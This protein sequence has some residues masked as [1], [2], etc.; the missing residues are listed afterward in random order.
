MQYDRIEVYSSK[1]RR[2]GYFS[3]FSE[4]YRYTQACVGP[5]ENAYKFAVIEYAGRDEIRLDVDVD[6]SPRSLTWMSGAPIDG[7]DITPCFGLGANW[8]YVTWPNVVGEPDWDH[9]ISFDHGG[10]T[11]YL[12]RWV[13][14]AG[15]NF[16]PGL[17]WAPEEA[18]RDVDLAFSPAFEKLMFVVEGTR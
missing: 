15:V 3:L 17:F 2:L 5:L 12:A 13:W 14:N 6:P 18:I 16:H 1:F 11:L 7:T 9:T 4:V 8:V 10:K